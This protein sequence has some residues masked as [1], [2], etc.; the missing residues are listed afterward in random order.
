MRY[1][2]EIYTA[3]VIPAI[4]SGFSVGVATVQHQPRYYYSAFQQPFS[5]PSKKNHKKKHTN[6][7]EES[8]RAAIA[9]LFVT[10]YKL[11]IH[12]PSH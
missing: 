4:F 1:K 2:Q 7:I 9:S 12:K 3:H 5:L 6:I 10:G 8:G 11:K